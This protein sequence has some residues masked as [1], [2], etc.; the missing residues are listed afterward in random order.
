MRLLHLNDRLSARGGAD[1]HLLSVVREQV[2]RG[3]DVQLGVGRI[4]GTTQAPCPVIEISPLSAMDRVDTALPAADVI[5]IHNV[6]NPAIISLGN[7][8]TVQD[9][10]TFCPG[11]GKLTLSDR[12]CRD[13]M[14]LDTCAG[15]FTDD[16]YFATILA[17]TQ[18]RLDA[19]ANPRLVVLSDYMRGEL[20]QVGLDATVIPPF[21]DDL[22]VEAPATDP[23]CV[24]FV[25]RV[26][27]A[28]GVFD[29]IEAWR[30]SGVQL[31]FVVAG[32]GRE[33]SRAESLGAD[34]LGWVDRDRLAG[35]YRSAAVVVFPSRWQEPFGI[36]G[37]EALAAS[38][39]VG[40]WESGGVADWHPGPLVPWGDV[41]ALA[42]ALRAAV[43]TPPNVLN[44]ARDFDR[45]DL[46]DRLD[47]V[48]R[49]TRGIERR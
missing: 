3:Y 21:V 10:R 8:M 6:M 32:T 39:P 7:V 27:A 41:D 4:D 17:R 45:D 13:A 24:L 44:T 46:M 35:L 9:H 30:R 28:K 12:V 43:D 18:R 19:L 25:G 29:A 40:A 22:D 49:Q 15:C 34:V 26:V 2:R 42:D 14:A 36:V 23:P 16:A 47:A 37:L 31:P 11:R 33:R 5:H 48:Y 20:Q 1:Q 38:T